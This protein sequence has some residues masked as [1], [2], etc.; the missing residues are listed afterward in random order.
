MVVQRLCSADLVNGLPNFY[1]IPPPKPIKQ[2]KHPC[3][4][5]A[6]GQESGPKVQCRQ[7]LYLRGGGRSGHALEFLLQRHAEAL[8]RLVV[9]FQPRHLAQEF[10]FLLALLLEERYQLPELVLAKFLRL[11]LHRLQLAGHH[12]LQVFDVCFQHAQF[13]FEAVAVVA[14]RRD[15]RSGQRAVFCRRCGTA[16]AQ[17]VLADLVDGVLA[18]LFGTFRKPVHQRGLADQVD[19]PRDAAGEI[20]YDVEHRPD[21]VVVVGDVNS[22]VACTLAAV[23]LGVKT[24]HL[25]AGLRSFDRTMPEEINRIVTD[26]IADILWTPSPDGDENLLREGV[27][28]EKIERVGNIMIDSLEM[29][30]PRIM[31]ENAAARYGLK[32]GSFGVVTLHRPANVDNPDIIGKLCNALTRIAADIPL[33]FPV[34]PRTRKNLE[35]FGLLDGFSKAPGMHL[36]E[37]VSY[38]PFM[39]LVFNCRLAITDSGGIQEETTYLGIPCLTLRPNTERPITVTAPTGS[40]RQTISSGR[41]QIRLRTNQGRSRWICGMAKPPG[42]WWRRQNASFIGQRGKVIF[43]YPSPMPP[44]IPDRDATPMIQRRDTNDSTRIAAQLDTRCRCRYYVG[45]FQEK[46]T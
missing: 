25:E 33:V 4:N 40:A 2:K 44:L 37:P 42:V 26:S 16:D 46:D 17:V 20:K 13:A 21:L 6:H 41:R 7:F 35:A 31:A 10:L 12:L 27:A 11:V 45:T 28:A 43:S 39:N 14:I 1:F 5:C 18:D 8:K 34:H 22:T 29:M 3:S 19:R 9:H 24:V 36:D 23:K 32:N 15:G 38:I 30:R